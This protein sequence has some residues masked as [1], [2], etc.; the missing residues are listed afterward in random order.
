MGRVI[1]IA[2]VLAFL[3]G[4]AS[5]STVPKIETQFV[6]VP[7]LYSPIPPVVERPKLMIDTL[8]PQSDAGDV[9]LAYRATVKQLIQYAEILELIISK[10]GAV[11]AEFE[12][13]RGEIERLYPA[14]V[15]EDQLPTP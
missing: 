10:Y 15:A 6:H 2:A 7:V 11:S 9:A 1:V 14:E 4:C 12:A 8:T 3:T 13:L 5:T